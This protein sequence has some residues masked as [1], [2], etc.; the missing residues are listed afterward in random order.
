ME[1]GESVMLLHL[2]AA[3]F[4]TQGWNIG[5]S[6]TKIKICTG[7]KAGN[8]FANEIECAVDKFKSLLR[9]QIVIQQLTK[10]ETTRVVEIINRAVERI[11]QVNAVLV[12]EEK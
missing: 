4:I 2:K 9:H 11:E 7:I 5:R 8:Q 10:E 12:A 1:K 3:V 6:S